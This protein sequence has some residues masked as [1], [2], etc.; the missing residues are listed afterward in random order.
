MLK[1]VTKEIGFGRKV[2]SYT[3]QVEFAPAYELLASSSIFFKRNLSRH[4]LYGDQWF[5]EVELQIGEGFKNEVLAFADPACW[6]EYMILLTHIRGKKEE[7]PKEFLQWVENIQPGELFELL[8]PY[9]LNPIQPHIGALK[10]QFV[11]LLH[12]WNELYFQ[13]FDLSLVEKLKRDSQEKGSLIG[14][15]SSQV[16]VEQITDLW[17]GEDVP[18]EK[19][20]LAPSIHVNPIKIIHKYNGMNII[21]YPV[22]PPIGE[23]EVPHQLRRITKALHDDNRIR[24]LQLIAQEQRTF[25]DIVNEIGLSKA[26][27]HQHLFVLRSAGLLRFHYYEDIYSINSHVLEKVKGVLE[28]FIF[29]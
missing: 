7:S 9:V 12:K 21:Y 19:I 18:L 16:V 25:T 29:G 28:G 14:K 3:T 24:I 1:W 2:M 4:L 15:F 10:N 22:D 5:K 27:V 6:S 11:D 13:F 17:I 20:V 8:S 26:T 23:G